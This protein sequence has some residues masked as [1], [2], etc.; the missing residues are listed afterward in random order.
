MSRKWFGPDQGQEGASNKLKQ[1]RL[2]GPMK[3]APR[4]IDHLKMEALELDPDTGALIL[5]N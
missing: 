3:L 1:V 5:V 2:K 4:M